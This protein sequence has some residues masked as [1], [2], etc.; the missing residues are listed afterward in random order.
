M[1]GIVA[2]ASATS[3]YSTTLGENNITIED[4]NIIGGYMLFVYT[5]RLTLVTMILLLRAIR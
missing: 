2:S 3:I 5:L 4:N 1:N